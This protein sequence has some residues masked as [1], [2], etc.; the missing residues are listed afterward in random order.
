MLVFFEA[1]FHIKLF[2]TCLQ[3]VQT[4]AS[5]DDGVM[6]IYNNSTEL[7]WCIYHCN[8]HLYKTIIRPVQMCIIIDND[9]LLLRLIYK[10]INCYPYHI[11][12]GNFCP[13]LVLIFYIVIKFS[14]IILHRFFLFSLFIY[15]FSTLLLIHIFDINIRI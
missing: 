14:D 13:Q 2:Y 6:C 10:L 15:Y 7:L 9:M 5:L 1:L 4:F 11:I 8:Y 3:W 12:N